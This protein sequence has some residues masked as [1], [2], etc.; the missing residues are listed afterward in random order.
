LNGVANTT[1]TE[2]SRRGSYNGTNACGSAG[3][4]TDRLLT[5]AALI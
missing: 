2:N 3:F 4:R 1:R 5:R